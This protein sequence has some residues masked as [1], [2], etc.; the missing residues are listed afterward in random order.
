MDSKKSEISLIVYHTTT[1]LSAK[2][3]MSGEEASIESLLKAEEPFLVYSEDRSKVVCTLNNH[4]LPLRL[5][6]LESFVRCVSFVLQRLHAPYI[7]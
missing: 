1:I 2:G 6:A 7:D 4:E 5:H 3:Y